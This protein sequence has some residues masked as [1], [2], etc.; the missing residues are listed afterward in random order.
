[1]FWC[2]FMYGIYSMQH[3]GVGYHALFLVCIFWY[4]ILH[5]HCSLIVQMCCYVKCVPSNAQNKFQGRQWKWL[6][7]D[8]LSEHHKFY[9]QPE[10]SPDSQA[11]NINTDTINCNDYVYSTNTWCESYIEAV[12]FVFFVFFTQHEYTAQLRLKKRR[13]SSHFLAQTVNTAYFASYLLSWDLSFSIYFK[14]KEFSTAF[15]WITALFSGQDRAAE[16]M[17]QLT[18]M[19]VSSITKKL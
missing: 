1:M 3:F 4:V 2:V 17:L 5:V 19:R 9:L 10:C 12:F 16:Y 13:A 11:E 15:W 7:Y 6:Q 8:F 14:I 18:V